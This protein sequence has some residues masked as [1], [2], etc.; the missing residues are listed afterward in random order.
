MKLRLLIAL[1]ITLVFLPVLTG[2]SPANVSKTKATEIALQ[3][4]GFST[5]EVSGLHTEY[6][7][8]D[9]IKK[10]EVKFYQGGLEYE[11]DID[12]ETGA[13]LGIDKDK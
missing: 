1:V 4:A 5:D 13:I 9:G 10:Y 12:A 8:A 3:H 6:D 2:C 7:I 11:Y